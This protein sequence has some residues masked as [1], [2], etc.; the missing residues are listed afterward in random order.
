MPRETRILYFSPKELASAIT[1]LSERSDA[2]NLA[3]Q[4]RSIS[5]MNGETV[6]ALACVAGQDDITLSESMLAAALILH[7]R[8]TKIPMA[9]SATKKLR[10][11]DGRLEMVMTMGVESAKAGV[12]RRAAERDSG[13]DKPADDASLLAALGELIEKSDDTARDAL[14]DWVGSLAEQNAIAPWRRSG[15]QWLGL[16]GEI[17][18]DTVPAQTMRGAWRTFRTR[19]QTADAFLNDQRRKNALDAISR[20][21]ILRSLAAAAKSMAAGGSMAEAL[22]KAALGWPRSRIGLVLACTGASKERP[23]DPSIR[24]VAERVLAF[25]CHDSAPVGETL[26]TWFTGGTVD[27]AV[28]SGA[29]EISQQYCHTI[30]VHC[31]QCP[32]KQG[33]ASALDADTRLEK[34]H[35]LYRAGE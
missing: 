24:R 31:T 18:L 33:C 12:A 6:S 25:D 22:E 29:W 19:W 9:K 17:A 16:M 1:Y 5:P 15:D 10:V 14:A 28:Y 35:P 11:R 27:G 23:D 20:G 8:R 21:G 4:V 13:R 30:M 2:L 26:V 3:G 32:L 7:C 34:E